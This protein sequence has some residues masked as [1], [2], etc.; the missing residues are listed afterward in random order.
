[1][2]VK[3]QPCDTS[4]YRWY[5]NSMQQSTITRSFDDPHFVYKYF[6]KGFVLDTIPF[7]RNPIETC[8]TEPLFLYSPIISETYSFRHRRG[9]A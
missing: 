1:M 9:K 8:E 4:G 5:G 6:N 2:N 7:K 3:V